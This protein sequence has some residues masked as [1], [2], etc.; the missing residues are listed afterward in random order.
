MLTL[1]TL[2]SAMIITKEFLSFLLHH[3]EKAL[4]LTFSVRF[5]SLCSY[6]LDSAISIS[7]SI[8]L[9]RESSFL[10]GPRKWPVSK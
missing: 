5:Q 2:F 9:P 8:N 6:K 7:Q 1:Y 10:S 3:L 4:A